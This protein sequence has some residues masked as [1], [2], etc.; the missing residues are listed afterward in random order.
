MIKKH[1]YKICSLRLTH[2]KYMIE[3]NKKK[4]KKET[5]T[6]QLNKLITT[7]LKLFTNTSV[8]SFIL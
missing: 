1:T 2:T 7:V 4:R 6:N 5:N 8:E 3:D